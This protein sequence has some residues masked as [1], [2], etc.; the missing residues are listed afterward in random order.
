MRPG[1]LTRLS[2]LE[3]DSLSFECCAAR[4]DLP[5]GEW[6]LAKLRNRRLAGGRNLTFSPATVQGSKLQ[7]DDNFRVYA[8]KI[9]Y[10]NSKLY[11]EP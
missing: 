7:R 11:I 3:M 9:E 4:V 6:H 5:E 8:L 2:P 1:Y 10:K